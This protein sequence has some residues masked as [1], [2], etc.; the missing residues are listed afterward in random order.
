[1]LLLLRASNPHIGFLGRVPGTR[2]YSDRDRHP[3][4][5]PLPGVLAFRPEASLLYVNADGV[6]ET[7]L[8]RLATEP[9]AIRMV[10]CDLS[11]APFI[12]LAG[13]R[14]LHN[15]HGE[16]AERGIALRIV[17]ARGQVRELLRADGLDVKVGG[18]ER[19][20][21]LDDLLSAPHA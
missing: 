14:M 16:L 15:L 11:S 7:V 18:V 8:A 9:T 2:T 4:N 20:V 12:D 5:E 17:G 3:E 21:T 19:G 10:V 6:L 13:S 1:V